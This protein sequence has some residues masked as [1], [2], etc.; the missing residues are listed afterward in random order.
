[1]SLYLT[2]IHP[3]NKMRFFFFFF[4]FLHNELYMYAFV[5]NL[6]CH[7]IP[8]EGPLAQEA[9]PP[10]EADFYDAFQKL[11]HALNLLVSFTRDHYNIHTNDC[12]ILPVERTFFFCN[13]NC[14]LHH[15]R[16]RGKK[17]ETVQLHNSNNIDFKGSVFSTHVKLGV[18][19]EHFEV[20]GSGRSKGTTAL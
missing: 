11:K 17:Y 5:V 20:V 19:G 6:L 4:F 7:V 16:Y 10:P 1:M 18:R 14:N 13:I 8:T 9:K 3:P 15:H 12:F 2:S